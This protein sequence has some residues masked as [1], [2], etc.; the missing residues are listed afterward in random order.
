MTK[1]FRLNISTKSGNGGILSHLLSSGLSHSP[2]SVLKSRKILK[3]FNGNLRG[4]KFAV[5]GLSFKPNTDDM[6]EA[7][8]ITIINSLLSKGA[9]VTAYDP[10][11]MENSKYYFGDKVGYA[12]DM[13]DA[14][15]GANALLLLTEW[16]E[17]RNPDF[18]KINFL[19]NQPVIFDGR[20]IYKIDTM[21]THQFTYYSIGRE[22]LIQQN[23][24][25]KNLILEKLSA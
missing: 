7:P 2:S 13:Y 9:L 20:N 1:V 10:A 15:R 23:V 5:W 21:D 8:S 16:N 11:A 3:H 18:E 19:M 14:L 12:E 6:R 25:A 22:S 24:A 4:K 17:F